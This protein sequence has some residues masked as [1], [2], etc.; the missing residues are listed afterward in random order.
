MVGIGCRNGVFKGMNL[1][2]EWRTLLF[3]LRLTWQYT[4]LH[5]VDC[6]SPITGGLLSLI[7]A[8]FDD[9]LRQSAAFLT[10]VK[11]VWPEVN[12]RRRLTSKIPV[13]FVILNLTCMNFK[14][15]HSFHL[16]HSEG[17]RRLSTSVPTYS[18]HNPS[19]RDYV[20]WQTKIG[21]FMYIHCVLS[22]F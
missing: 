4:T 13:M 14:L 17:S 12:L 16:A 18:L 6:P 1:A 10:L 2:P 21:R 7:G 5:K 15:A 22:S 8:K 9:C 11:I 20:I 3:W 19:F